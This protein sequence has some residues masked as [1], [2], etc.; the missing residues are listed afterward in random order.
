MKIKLIRFIRV[1][2]LIKK[3]GFDSNDQY[4]ANNRKKRAK[5]ALIGWF[6][7]LN[8]DE[9]NF[10]IKALNNFR[11]YSNTRV[12]K[13]FERLINQEDFLE[14]KSI[15]E[16]E[17]VICM[18]L[19]KHNDRT[20]TSIS[21]FSTFINVLNINSMNTAQEDTVKWFDNYIKLSDKYKMYKLKYDNLKKN[22]KRL[23]E[24]EGL[25]NE[26]NRVKEDKKSIKKIDERIEKNRDEYEKELT[27]IEKKIDEINQDHGHEFEAKSIIIV[28][29]FLCSG[30]SVEK[31][32]KAVNLSMKKID[33]KIYLVFLESTKEGRE[34]VEGGSVFK[35]LS[36]IKICSLETAINFEKE[37]LKSD[38]ERDAF[39]KNKK[40]VYKRYRIND[41][42]LYKPH[43][44]FS[45]WVNAPNSNFGFLSMN[46]KEK[47]WEAPFP[48]S[49][50]S[51]KK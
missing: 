31:F 44:I 10:F 14:I 30:T 46:N 1:H 45:S 47:G 20:E 23:S 29:D 13:S 5:S 22:D 26:K 15:I 32:L 9:L 11:Y 39:N 8:K 34:R 43:T 36:N 25:E 48:R 3:L 28:D 33:K 42:T 24:I 19:K 2:L 17:S 27:E 4:K 12:G 16:S 7:K 35:G 51:R 38:K 40:E 41:N 18:P 50:R 21:M 6:D 37:I 49:N